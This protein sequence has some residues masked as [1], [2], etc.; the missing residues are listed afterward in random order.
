MKN[1][2]EIKEESLKKHFAT[3][4]KEMIE[5]LGFESVSARKIA[6]KSGYSCATI[7]NHFG[8]MDNLLWYT[9]NLMIEDVVDYMKTNS[10]DSTV[11]A[12][13]IKKSFL[14]YT[15]YF[16]KNKNIFK[17]L[18]FNQLNKSEQEMRQYLENPEF[19][20]M[21]V[22]ILNSLKEIG[23]LSDREVN[24]IMKTFIH[25]IHGMLVLLV[26]SNDDYTKVEMVSDISDMVD[27]M[28]NRKL[29]DSHRK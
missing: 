18:F 22:K 28:L 2:K 14:T 13:S 21:N 1:K 29:G 5:E 3:T 17:F 25:S 7:Y 27:Y 16:I 20:D 23:K 19:I 9:R 26:S 11:T 4:T 12:E 10:D 8:N 6:E 15:E 24:T